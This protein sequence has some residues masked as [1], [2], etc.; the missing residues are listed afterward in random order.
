MRFITKL[1]SFCLISVV[2]TS[3]QAFT[4]NLQDNGIAEVV[5]K[6]ENSVV[7]VTARVNVAVY[8][9]RRGSGR[10]GSLFDFFFEVPN[11][12][13]PREKGV[14]SGFIYDNSGLILTNNHVIEGA[15]DITV[16]MKDGRVYQ[17]DYLGGDPT[18]DIAVL[19]INDKDFDGS[20]APRFVAEL[21]DSGK[22]RVGEWVIAIGSP[23]KLDQTVTLGIVSAKGRSLDFKG[24]TSYNNLI[25]TDASINPGNSGGPLLDINGKVVGINT[26]INPMGQGLGFAIPVN[27]ARRITGDLA[28]FGEVRRSWLGVQIQD[29]T[30]E[31]ARQKNLRLAKG[32]NVVRVIPG[33]P[34]SKAGL[35]D[36]DIIIRV[37]GTLVE[38]REVLIGKI[39]EIPVGEE[40]KFQILRDNRPIELK[41]T[42]SEPSK[43]SGGTALNAIGLRIKD[44]NFR[45]R[46]SLRL[47][48]DL[49]GVLVTGVK[50][51]SLAERSGLQEND[52]IIQVNRRKV[53]DSKSLQKA[54]SAVR[55]SRAVFLVIIR[56]G[57]LSY[58]ELN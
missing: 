19:K 32:V 25:Q 57:Y 58:I 15:D 31:L 53:V 7:H 33:T 47:D 26:A 8:G 27:L 44:L 17:C 5:Q 3:L 50:P 4:T 55:N 1:L 28:K 34:A 6:V 29:L 23:F 56:Q 12:V 20:F 45:D 38:N 18:R 39:Q 48:R 9:G 24:Q 46:R 51:N 43:S 40:G 42:L 21:G 10:F 13:M 54:L 36:G 49:E 2:L 14:G 16:T 41:I 37:N 52:L 30:P 35:L 22:L 11:N